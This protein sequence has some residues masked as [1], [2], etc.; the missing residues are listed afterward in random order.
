MRFQDLKTTYKLLAGGTTML[1]PMGAL[2]MWMLSTQTQLVERE[3][4][5]FELDVPRVVALD[6]LRFNLAMVG[7][8]VRL[9]LQTKDLAR[10]AAAS[11]AVLASH[12]S[13]VADLQALRPL[14]GDPTEQRELDTF[15]AGLERW[16]AAIDEAR[17]ATIGDHPDQALEALDRAGASLPALD[18]W[19]ETAAE[20][21]RA[22]MS[23]AW[24]AEQARQASARTI[25]LALMAVTLIFL[26]LVVWVVT[27][28]ISR[29]AQIV[30]DGLE[31]IR[32]GDFTRPILVQGRDEFG[33]LAG[34]INGMVSHV[35]STLSQV[36]SL[37]QLLDST[38]KELRASATE[39]SSGASEQASG[40]EETAASLEEITSTVKQTSQN[41]GRAT[42]LAN[43]SREVAQQ[44]QGVAESAIT[45]MN[46]LA[47][48]SR[49][50]AE[51]VTTID[52][53]AFQTNL[54]ALNAAV[55]AARAGDQG[56]GFAV[57]A[58][59]VR[60]L[61]QRSASSAKEIKSLIQGSVQRVES[62]VQLVNQ[63]GA[64]LRGIVQ[65]VTQV[66]DLMQEIA[67][68]S[69]EQ[70]LGVDQVNKAVTTMDQVTQRNAAQ[71]AE[72][73]AA[74]T[75]L[76]T[77]AVR[78]N[79]AVGA[80]MLTSDASPAGGFEPA[81]ATFPSAGKSPAVRQLHG[82]KPDAEF[83]EF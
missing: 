10:R 65:A 73:S 54:L 20:R 29:A 5:F 62:S 70:S 60:N 7:R 69:K 46:E 38:A 42:E 78:L 21:V 47:T 68:G 45:A 34:S 55:E 66:T 35:S 83:Q 13:L 36:K 56:R 19:T 9:Q 12:R 58:N 77:T 48:S 50:M 79:E 22:G 33:E 76:S 14:L 3:R 4:G 39:I 31:P 71:T 64:S 67:A 80:F 44:G 16:W 43:H 41:A 81:L 30:T 2:V 25:S 17:L 23:K 15:Q 32:R 72:L 26:C 82:Q 27:R 6:D 57:V 1:I 18:A 28:A 53:I 37:A 8:N 63:S 11:E 24:E 40:F 49:Q 51:I 61:A 74:A 52:E 59:E 75:S